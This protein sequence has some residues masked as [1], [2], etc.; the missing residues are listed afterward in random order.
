METSHAV[1]VLKALADGI[2]PFTGK[3]LPEDNPCQH[4]QVIRSLFLA[5]RVLECSPPMTPR[6]V[7]TEERNVPP[8]AGKAWTAPEDEALCQRFE[9]GMSIEQMAEEHFRTRGSITARLVRLGK[10]EARD[11]ADRAVEARR[12]ASSR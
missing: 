10:I 2:D 3:V 9:S 12:Q 1:R 7:P 5:V 6:R 11:Q 8:N 4:P